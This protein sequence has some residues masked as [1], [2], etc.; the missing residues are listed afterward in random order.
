MHNFH[1]STFSS[2]YWLHCFSVGYIDR[3]QSVKLAMLI[4]AHNSYLSERAIQTITLQRKTSL[5]F[6]SRKG[7]EISAIYHTIIE[8]CK[9]SGISA[10]SYLKRFFLEMAKGRNDFENLL[11]ATIGKV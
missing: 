5:L 11:P 8:T 3:F 1:T 7:V 6:G 10:R 2:A 4:K 9:L